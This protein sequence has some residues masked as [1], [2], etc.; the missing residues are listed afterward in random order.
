MRDIEYVMILLEVFVYHYSNNNNNWRWFWE[1]ARCHRPACYI[2]STQCEEN[3]R[4]CDTLGTKKFE[5]CIRS[6]TQIFFLSYNCNQFH[7]LMLCFYNWNKVMY[8]LCFYIL[9]LSYYVGVSGC[10]SQ[11]CTRIIGLEFFFVII[12]LERIKVLHY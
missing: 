11:R 8:T 3:N 1:L 7:L 9:I 5:S 4:L 12:S 6:W 2:L 10:E